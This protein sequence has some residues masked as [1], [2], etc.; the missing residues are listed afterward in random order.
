MQFTS[1]CTLLVIWL[2]LAVYEISLDYGLSPW[3][4]WILF[5]F[6]E[7]FFFFK[8]CP[9]A[10]L[11][12]LSSHL[13]LPHGICLLSPF[14]ML[15]P[16]ALFPLFSSVVLIYFW[17]PSATSDHL[18]FLILSPFHPHSN[19]R[20]PHPTTQSLIAFCSAV[21][22]LPCPLS[23]SHPSSTLHQGLG[24]HHS[25]LHTSSINLFLSLCPHFHFLWNALFNWP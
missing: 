17:F 4:P 5:T 23:T 14:L 10:T 7:I 2:S 16:F 8:P 13:L 25:Y 15:A 20:T 9:S 6:F 22:C 24:C 18:C 1:T 21:T 12:G 11:L 19:T 3:V